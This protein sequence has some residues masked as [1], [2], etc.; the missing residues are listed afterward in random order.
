MSASEDDYIDPFDAHFHRDPHPDAAVRVVVVDT[1]VAGRAAEVARS[2]EELLRAR[3]RGVET[4]VVNPAEEGL[5]EALARGIADTAAPLV[6][7]TNA[8]EPWTDG[9]LAPLLEAINQCDHV[10]GR[11]PLGLVRWLVRWVSSWPWRWV[12]AVPTSD[13]HSPCRLHRRDKLAAIP[14]QS[15]SSF[16]AV[17]LLAKATFLGHLIDEVAV[18]TLA[19]PRAGVRWGDVVTVFTRPCF[20]A[21]SGPAEDLEGEQEG[22][23]GPECQDQKCG[24]DVDEAGPLEDH[25]AEG[26]EQLGQ[27][28]GQDEVL[29]RPLEAR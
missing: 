8:L 6:L 17:E 24:R 4:V 18:P 11:R 2:V 15:S 29:D 27:G 22:Q 7:V 5:A 12:F 16:A 26:V 14:L 13:T 21:G 10:V 9:Q 25:G 1:G 3:G 23:H 28:Q 20:V 19:A